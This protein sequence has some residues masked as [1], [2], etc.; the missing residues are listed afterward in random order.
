M[1]VAEL[2]VKL[3]LE[4]VTR[5]R[6][7]FQL[8]L[9]VQQQSSNQQPSDVDSES[10]DGFTSE[11]T[12]CIQKFQRQWRLHLSHTHQQR[13]SLTR[14]LKH[15]QIARF[16]R[17]TVATPPLLRVHL[18]FFL[19]TR[20]VQAMLNLNETQIRFSVLHKAVKAAVETASE[21]AYEK[22]GE[23]LGRCDGVQETLDTAAEHLSDGELSKVIDNGNLEEIRSCF[24]RIQSHVEKVNGEIMDLEELFAETTC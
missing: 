9:E 2:G 17:L 11:Q 19:T 5:N 7:L 3:N 8:S 15:G 4:S 24:E 1:P 16:Q 12:E 21:S 14:S 23:A 6:L 20:G 13:L 10:E 22:V 18:R